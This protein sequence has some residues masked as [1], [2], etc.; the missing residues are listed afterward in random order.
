MNC[1]EGG[2][3]L[4]ADRNYFAEPSPHY[5]SAALPQVR[6]AAGIDGRARVYDS[7]SREIGSIAGWGSDIAAIESGCG[8]GWQV[9]ASKPT[10]AGEPDAIQAYEMTGAG[11]T[12]AGD[13]ALFPGPVTALWSGG[14][15]AT[16]VTRI[17]ETGRYAAYS[18]S[19][20]CG[21]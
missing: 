1:S 4:A 11:A 21:R 7:S 9:V 10:D 20:S 2:S 8:S 19:I 15:Q 13:P 12:P 18:L 14:K 17:A 6:I 5:S 16:V 3:R